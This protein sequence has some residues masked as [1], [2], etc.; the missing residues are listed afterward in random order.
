MKAD[1][2]C[3][4]RVASLTRFIAIGIIC[5]ETAPALAQE[6]SP[7]R[8]AAPDCELADLNG[9][10]IKLSNFRGHVVILDFW[11]TWCAAC[12]MEIPHFVDLQEQYGNKGLAVIGVSL[13]EQGPEVVKKFV[14]QFS[15][16]YPIAIGSEKVAEAYGGIDAL[17]TTFVIDRQGRI[18][19][20][21][22]GYDDK[23]SSKKK[24]SHCYSS[25]LEN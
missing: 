5:L 16:N 2:V 25:D 7:A 19:S 10:P 18:V 23:E 6:A 3:R 8:T 15:V 11:A 4:I 21:H 12:R 9:K 13:D 14:K 17:P 1:C 20:R 22:I 24:F